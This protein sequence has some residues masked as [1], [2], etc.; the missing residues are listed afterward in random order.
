M[1]L[2]QTVQYVGRNYSTGFQ[3]VYGR[4]GR[5][6]DVKQLTRVRNDE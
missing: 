4:R 1:C 2:Q 6:V 5:R 3:R